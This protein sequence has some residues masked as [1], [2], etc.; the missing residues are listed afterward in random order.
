LSDVIR[1][2]R[3]STGPKASFSGLTDVG[4]R[5]QADALNT[6]PFEAKMLDRITAVLTAL[7]SVERNTRPTPGTSYASGT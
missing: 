4:K 7:E 1:E 6:S 2:F 5:V 3:M